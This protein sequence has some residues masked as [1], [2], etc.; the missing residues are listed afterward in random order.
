MYELQVKVCVWGRGVGKGCSSS[1]WRG[2][3]KYLADLSTDFP[4]D[5]YRFCLYVL[6]RQFRLRDVLLGI[7]LWSFHNLGTYVRLSTWIG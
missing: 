1:L 2:V 7:Y 5:R 3:R 6:F 4:P